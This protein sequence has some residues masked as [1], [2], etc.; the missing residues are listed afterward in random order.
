MEGRNEAKQNE[1]KVTVLNLETGDVN[2]FCG[3]R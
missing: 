3:R 2:Y 1:A